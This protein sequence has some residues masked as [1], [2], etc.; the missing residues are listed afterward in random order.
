[1]H[2]H[3][4]PLEVGE[5]LV[6]Q[7]RA[8]ARALDQA[9]DVSDHQLAVIRVDG[10]EDGLDRGERVGRDLRLRVRDSAQER[11]LARVREADERGVR[12]QLEAQLEVALL[13]GEA[14]LGET[15]R[16]AGR[17]RKT[18]VPAPSEAAA[19]EH[20][21]SAAAGQIGD[22]PALGVE[23]LRSR[24]RAQHDVVTCR[25]V[26]SGASARAALASLEALLRPE[27]REV[28]Q[29]GVRDEHDVAAGAAV[30]AV[31]AALGHVLLPPEAERAV[32]PATRLHVD[33]GAI[34]E[35]VT[36][37]VSSSRRSRSSGGLRST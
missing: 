27:A 11:R 12:K 9:R 28:A 5:K 26:T 10:P 35:H 34:R 37:S 24:G 36:E 18:F 6:P 20:D 2:E 1:V 23:H 22:E 17:G 15:R 13:A 29:V 25:A 32:A 33:A 7:P 4:C 8:L 31:R 30:A 21:S 14:G 16:L 3:A 19:G